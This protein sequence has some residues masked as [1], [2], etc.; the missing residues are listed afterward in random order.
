MPE[1]GVGV[2][3]EVTI[4]TVLIYQNSEKQGLSFLLTNDIQDKEY[5]LIALGKINEKH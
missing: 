2:E 5:I 3:R 1:K 4:S